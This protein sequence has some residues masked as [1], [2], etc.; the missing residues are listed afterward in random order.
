M[1]VIIAGSRTIRDASLVVRAIRDSSFL[2][3][4][5][6]SGGARGVDAIGE[7]WARSRGIPVEY[8]LPDWT[9]GKRAG[10][11]R[12]RRM[13]AKAHAL[14][15]VWDGESRGSASMLQEA[16]AAG[17]KIHVLS[18]PRTKVSA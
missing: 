12:N 2:V 16:R 1:R 4:R 6:L 9:R 11:E 10:P 15:L 13:A 17:L 5:V 18:V 14:I 8:F 3:T 7:E